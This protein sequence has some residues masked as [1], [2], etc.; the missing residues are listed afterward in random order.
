ML[1]EKNA[2]FLMYAVLDTVD[3]CQLS[4]A[5]LNTRTASENNMQ[6]SPSLRLHYF[7]ID[8]SERSNFTVKEVKYLAYF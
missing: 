2:H 6:K 5:M 7:P 1:V 4:M 3:Q 8:A